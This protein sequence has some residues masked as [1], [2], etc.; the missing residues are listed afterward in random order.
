M[1]PSP[2]QM[3]QV[4]GQWMDWLGGIAAQNKLVDRGN[5]LSATE[6]KTL[7]S[8]DM[9]TDGPYTEIK[10][11]ISGYT[12]VSTSTIDDAVEIAKGCPI[13]R[14]GGKVEVREVIMPD[15]K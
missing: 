4:M 8:A 1:R 14:F 7:E 3:Q 2:E 15:A 13:F 12:I 5:R 11:Y 10:E 6:T 9:V